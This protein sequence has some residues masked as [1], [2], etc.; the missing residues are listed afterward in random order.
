VLYS[1]L[2]KSDP[3]NSMVANRAIS[4]ALAGGN[5]AL[6]LRLAS[7]R[8][9][10]QLGLDTRL[11]LAAD[12]LSRGKGKDALTILRTDADSGSIAFLA[13]LV[14]AWI[15]AERR[16][17]RALEIL[18][19]VPAGSIVAPYVNDHRA[20][21]LLQLKRPAEALPLI[22]RALKQ[23][24]GREAR[25]RLA[26]A[27]GLVRSGNRANAL[28]LLQTNEPALSV[29]RT[30]IAAGKRPGGGIDSA[31]GGFA[32]LLS[33]IA[34][35][36][37]RS[38]S[39]ALPVAMVQVARLA[40]PGH[41]TLPI[42]LA[43]LL[44]ESKRTDDAIGVLRAMPDDAP[45][46]GAAREAE[47]RIL[48]RDGRLDEAVARAQ[49]FV[50]APNNQAGDWARLGDALDDAKRYGPAA[51]AFGR[52]IAMLEQGSPGPERW[53]LYL[54]RGAMLE[55]ADRWTEAK[56][57]LDKAR[58]LAPGSPVV[59][60]FLG[61]AQ[62]ERGENLDQA[63]ALI[64]EA[65]RRAPDDASITDSLGWAQ[66][67]R[68]KVTDAIATLERAAVAD[69]GQSEIHEHLGDALYTAG[70]RFEARHAWNAALI[71]AEDD[72]KRRVE[73]KLQIGLAP[74][75]AAP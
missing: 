17:R 54:L 65:S 1:A 58:E 30:R 47:L 9:V 44:G 43:L 73:A 4:Q 32:E 40:D 36:L 39:R 16:D 18:S 64:A 46:A 5:M 3:G 26:F 49:A 74:T 34:I 48:S 28:A 53:Q 61:Y 41:P 13:P 14:E 68:G 70:R 10:S 66:F 75:N 20:L 52:A 7:A 12:R 69:P 11:L 2:A 59:L 8:P 23:A 55:R 45:F 25:L 37:N 71:T 24:G 72:A 51:D 35:D 19:Q 38:D 56:Q 42:L 29:A 50:A 33:G 27:D 57:S 62:L 67:K 63:E 6:A 21:I 60:N 15:A 22:E 31:A